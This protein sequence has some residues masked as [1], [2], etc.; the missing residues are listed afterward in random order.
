MCDS[1]TYTRSVPIG[2]ASV[3]RLTLSWCD[4]HM[5]KDG[6]GGEELKRK[7]GAGKHTKSKHALQ[8]LKL[9]NTSQAICGKQTFSNRLKKN[10][11][12]GIFLFSTF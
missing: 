10:T 2:W 7:R 3:S 12:L 5:M 1:H 9:R 4:W 6:A 8:E 11:S